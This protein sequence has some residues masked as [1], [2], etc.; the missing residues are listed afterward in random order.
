MKLI[1]FFIAAIATAASLNIN[2][3]NTY[4]IFLAGQS[5]D[6]LSR[7]EITANPVVSIIGIPNAVESFELSFLNSNGDLIVVPS[8]SNLLTQRMLEIIQD[9]SV[10]KI[11][12]ENIVFMI[13]DEKK[14]APGRRFYL[15][16]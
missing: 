1:T 11:F 7:K 5:T 8:G 2:A 12:I 16:S 3:Q 13:N 14:T 10:N 6:T 4:K 9:T 15:K